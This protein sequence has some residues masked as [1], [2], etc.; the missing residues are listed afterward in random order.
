MQ[1]IYGVVAFA[2]Y[3]DLWVSHHTFGF[4]EQKKYSS[5]QSMYW[6]IESCFLVLSDNLRVSGFITEKN[7]S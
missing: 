6:K 3:D 7:A 4:K 5:L 1:F 2:I